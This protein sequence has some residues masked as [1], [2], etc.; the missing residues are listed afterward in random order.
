MFSAA[1]MSP[2]GAYRY[3]LSRLWGEGD[4]PGVTFVM[5]NPSTA[6]AL[7]DDPTIRRCIGFA[8]REGFDSLDVVNLFGLRSTRPQGLLASPDPVGPGNMEMVEAIFMDS[9]LIIAGWGSFKGLNLRPQIEAIL[10]LGHPLKCLGTNTDGMPK[11]P[12]YLPSDTPL[13]DWKLPS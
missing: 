12:L 2:C 8:K 3:S 5:L 13:Q 4:I 11:H 9:S 6:D 10:A 1:T 7:Q